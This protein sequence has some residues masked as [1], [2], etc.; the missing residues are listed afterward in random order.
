LSVRRREETGENSILGQKKS[1]IGY[2]ATATKDKKGDSDNNVGQRGARDGRCPIAKG[3]N[4][5]EAGHLLRKG[6]GAGISR[7]LEGETGEVRRSRKSCELRRGGG[8]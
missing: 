8:A 3:T 5:R 1:K 4:L 2:T 7:F 6:K